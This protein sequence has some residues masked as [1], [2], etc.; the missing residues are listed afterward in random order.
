MEMGRQEGWGSSQ[1]SIQEGVHFIATPSLPSRCHHSIP[2][3]CSSIQG[4]ARPLGPVCQRKKR[5]CELGWGGGAPPG[6]GGGGSLQSLA[7]QPGL[8]SRMLRLEMG[9]SSSAKGSTL[10]SEGNAACVRPGLP[11]PARPCLPR[12]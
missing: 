6:E 8:P 10:C 3:P 1:R 7:S 9:P 4:L 12:S 5:E 11:H 2:I